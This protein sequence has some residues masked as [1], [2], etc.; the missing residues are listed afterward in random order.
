MKIRCFKVL[1]NLTRL[2]ALINDIYWFQ[3]IHDKLGYNYKYFCFIQ[4]L[5][6]L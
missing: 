3:L 6:T 1:G 2:K 5:W 4:M